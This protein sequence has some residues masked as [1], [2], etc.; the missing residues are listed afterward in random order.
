MVCPGWSVYLWFG[1]S[2]FGFNPGPV[3]SNNAIVI[4]L[5]S[6]FFKTSSL[7]PPP[8]TDSVKTSA[9]GGDVAGGAGPGLGGIGAG[10]G[11][12]GVVAGGAGAGLGG[13]GVAAGVGPGVLA[14]GS[15]TVAGSSPKGSEGDAALFVEGIF[16]TNR[17]TTTATI[18]VSRFIKLLISRP[19]P[20]LP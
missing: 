3:F 2:I 14:S 8:L 13:V 7:G 16:L 6:V 9:G 11:G 10:A 18:C 17:A 19:E 15:S 4:G 20:V 5:L 12:G 1:S